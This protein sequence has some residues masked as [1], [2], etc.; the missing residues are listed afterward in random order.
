M[1]IARALQES[2][3]NISI[4]ILDEPTANLPGAD[5]DR[6]FDAVRRLK[7]RGIAV[8]FVSHHLEEVFEIAD[9]VTVLRD[10]KVVATVETKELEMS[11]LIE[12]IVGHKVTA[13][14]INRS[15]PGRPPPPNSL[16]HVMPIQP[17][18]ASSCE[19]SL[20]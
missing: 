17:R 14:T 9:R 15:I 5:V 13:A 18:A 1:A 3:R 8:V 6:L 10:A 2:D 16:G 19:N 4:L 20:E 12:L 11:S 7:A